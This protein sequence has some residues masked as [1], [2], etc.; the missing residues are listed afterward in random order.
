MTTKLLRPRILNQ[1]LAAALADL[2]HGELIFIADAGSGTS[3]K[4]LRSLAP[5]VEILDL[6][7]VTGVPS[8]DD[9]VPVICDVGDIEAC[10]V[11]KDMR[12]ANPDGFAMLSRLFDEKHIY[13]VPYI[14]DYYDLR[15]RCKLFVQTGDYRVHANVILVGGY[16]SA[17]IPMDMIL[18]GL[19]PKTK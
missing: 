16:P 19:G 8:I 5:D 7:V 9:L 3:A 17:D 18:N 11:T 1:R 2:R 10:I 12:G 6:E 15:D 14:P 13:E 4:A